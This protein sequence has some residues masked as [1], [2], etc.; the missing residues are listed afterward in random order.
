MLRKKEN[1]RLP[2]GNETSKRSAFS[3]LGVPNVVRDTKVG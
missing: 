3:L 2:V 1:I